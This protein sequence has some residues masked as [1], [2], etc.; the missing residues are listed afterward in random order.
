M[1]SPHRFRPD[2][3]AAPPTVGELRARRTLEAAEAMLVG[4][5]PPEPAHR[6][7]MSAES[8]LM[9]YMEELRRRSAGH[10]A[11]RAS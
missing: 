6:A 9:E 7:T 8:E 2:T 4:T 1:S 11:T 10:A 3:H 5:L